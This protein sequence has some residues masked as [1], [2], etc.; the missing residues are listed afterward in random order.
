MKIS[1]LKKTITISNSLLIFQ[2]PGG[3]DPADWS[4]LSNSS[5]S[6]DNIG[7]AVLRI[8]TSVRDRLTLESPS[9]VSLNS[10]P[11]DFDN[12]SQSDTNSLSGNN[13]AEL[14]TDDEPID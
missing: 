12:N 10:D 14:S 13:A 8:V 2:V 7:H 5:A 9:N 1:F 6:P 3:V 11:P 4:V